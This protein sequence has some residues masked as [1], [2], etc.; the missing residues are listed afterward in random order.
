MYVNKADLEFKMQELSFETC[1]EQSNL[2]Q[3][4]YSTHTTDNTQA[5]VGF[6]LAS[7]EIVIL[8]LLASLRFSSK[9]SKLDIVHN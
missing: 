5:A 7:A 9:Y 1:G 8:P 3:A 2:Q 4:H 6:S